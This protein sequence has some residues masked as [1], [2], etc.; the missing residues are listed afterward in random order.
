[1]SVNVVFDHSHR[2]FEFDW[3]AS[4]AWERCIFLSTAGKGWLPENVGHPSYPSPVLSFVLALP[5]RCDAQV[6]GDQGTSTEWFEAASRGF[7]AFD[8][9]DLRSCYTLMAEPCIPILKPDLPTDL[10]RLVSQTVINVDHGARV[11][12]ANGVR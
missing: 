2:G 7:Y 8:W 5:V 6:H 9:D 12:R 1:M 11:V 3:L 10:L 4:D